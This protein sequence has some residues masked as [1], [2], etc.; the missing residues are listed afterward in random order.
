ME[1]I[2]QLLPDCQTVVISK[3][4]LDKLINISTFKNVKTMI[5]KKCDFSEYFSLTHELLVVTILVIVPRSKLK[6]IKEYVI[7]GIQ[8]KVPNLQNMYFGLDN[9]NIDYAHLQSVYTNHEPKFN[10]DTLAL[11]V[12]FKVHELQHDEMMYLFKDPLKY[13]S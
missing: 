12:P 4:V 8:K 9:E 7:Q 2:A 5:F 13:L 11:K 3:L 6:L 10:L 1:R